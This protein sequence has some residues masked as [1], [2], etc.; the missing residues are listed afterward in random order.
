MTDRPILPIPDHTPRAEVVRWSKPHVH[1]SC[2][3]CGGI[4]VHQIAFAAHKPQWRA[5][6]CGIGRSAADRV[7]GYVFTV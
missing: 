2:T 7:A 6:G 3:Y 1:V 5:P 4:H